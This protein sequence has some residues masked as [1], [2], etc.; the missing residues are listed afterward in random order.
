MFC[1]FIFRLQVFPYCLFNVLLMLTL[2]IVDDHYASVHII[3]SSSQGHS[4]L[5]LVVAFLLVSRVNTGLKRYNQARDH[6]GTMYRESRELIQSCCV[7]SNH[8]VDQAAKEWRNR[9]AYRTMLL[10]RLSM[11]VIDY[12]EANVPAWDL[13]ELRGAEL[14]DIKASLFTN[15]ANRRWAHSERSEW[16]ETMRVPIRMAYLLRKT[17]HSQGTVLSEPIALVQENQML[18]SINSFM[19]GYY[20]IR[21]FVTTP[22]PFPLIQMARTFLFLYVFTV[23]FVLLRDDSSRFAH[24]FAVFLL[25]YGFMGLEVV[26]IELDN[27]FGDDEN[28]FDNM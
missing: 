6:L 25:T 8:T 21:T 7:F 24:C 14:E 26:A 28:D 1:Y 10:L 27:P 22:V 15:P 23:P 11:A 9:V 18:A 4:F 2:E 20:G 3:E 5:T 13:P 17:V 16:E 19:G 12:P